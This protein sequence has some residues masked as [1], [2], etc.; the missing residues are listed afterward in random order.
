MRSPAN[1]VTALV[2]V[3][4]P[5]VALAAKLTLPIVVLV[6]L[7]IFTILQVTAAVGAVSQWA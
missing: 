1:V 5:V 6:P 3:N 2:K 4:V 7:E